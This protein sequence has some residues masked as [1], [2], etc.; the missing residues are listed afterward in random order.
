M[1][2]ANYVVIPTI[3]YDKPSRITFQPQQHHIII[4]A[5]YSQGMQG[6]GAA[7]RTARAFKHL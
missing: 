2:W 1:W 4:N 6:S 3:P 7:A 5:T